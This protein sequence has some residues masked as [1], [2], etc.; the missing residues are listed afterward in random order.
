MSFEELHKRISPT[1]K[2]IAYRLNGHYTFF[3]HD[4]LYQEAL[5]HLWQEFLAGSLQDKTDSYI[6]Q[7]C[8]FHLKN[9]IR[10]TKTKAIVVSLE[11]CAYENEEGESW[12]ETI[13]VGKDD[14]RDYREHLDAKLMAETIRNNGLIPR[15]K[16]ILAF[17]AEGLTTREMGARLGVSHVRVVKLMSAIRDKCRRHADA[18]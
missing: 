16:E 10:K 12:L 1:L 7:G 8:Y 11:G 2:R 13:C 15:E 3:N 9:H 17:C 6:L 18:E 14:S 5:M 4:D